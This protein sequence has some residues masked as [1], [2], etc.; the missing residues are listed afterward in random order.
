M[1]RLI[2]L[3]REPHCTLGGEQ[4]RILPLYINF[5]PFRTITSRDLIQENRFT[6]SAKVFATR[7]MSNGQA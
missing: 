2:A 3:Q 4:K 1:T 7:F 5:S 6:C